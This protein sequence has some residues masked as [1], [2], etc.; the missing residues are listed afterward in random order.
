[1]LPA[2][3]RWAS[4]SMKI[5]ETMPSSRS[6]TR[7]SCGV[8]LTM[9]SLAMQDR[10]RRQ[11]PPGKGR[12]HFAPSRRTSNTLLSASLGLVGE[13]PHPHIEN[14]AH[15]QE[16][17]EDGGATIAQERQREP[18]HWDEARNHADIV[19]NLKREPGHD[20]GGEEG[21]EAIAGEVGGLEHPPQD[22]QVQA[23]DHRHPDEAQL[24]REHG[25]DEVG[26]SRGQVAELRLAALAVPL[27]EETPRAHRDLGLDLLVARA[28]RGERKSQEHTCQ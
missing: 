17:G 27:A 26:V 16:G 28:P 23:E 15:S 22:E 8:V 14:Q 9:R 1:M 7:V 3:P 21:P 10:G 19:H 12:R 20:G 2:M 13:A 24:L 25:E 18:L 5:S 11:A 4:R 6:A